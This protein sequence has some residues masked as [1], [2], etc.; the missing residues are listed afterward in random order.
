MTTACWLW[1]ISWQMVLSSSS[2]PPGASPKAISSF[3]LHAIQRL[4]VTHAT[5]ANPMPVR[6]HTVSRIVGTSPMALTALV[7]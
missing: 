6:R 1:R 3:T 4:S 2:S 5:A 7:A